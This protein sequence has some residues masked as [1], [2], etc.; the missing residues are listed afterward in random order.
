LR[1]RLSERYWPK[2]S[3]SLPAMGTGDIAGA[4]NLGIQGYLGDLPPGQSLSSPVLARSLA[5]R[6]S[7]R[8]V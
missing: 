6:R 4:S 7:F 1:L 3:G 5:L 2:D 8:V